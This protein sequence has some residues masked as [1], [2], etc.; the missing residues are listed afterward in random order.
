MKKVIAIVALLMIVAQAC[1][2]IDVYERTVSFPDHTWRSADS[3]SFS[4]EIA[5]SINPYQAFFVLRHSDAYH[6]KNIWVDI[7]VKDP[8]STYTV[9]REFALANGQQWLGTGMDDMYDHRIAFSK[10]PHTLKKGKYS[11]IV[12]QIMREDP[13]QNVWAAGIRMEKVK[14]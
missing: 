2:T 7:Q 9:T 11:F 1:N 8:D 3:L 4:F 13:L 14:Q 12:R 10:V 6:Y 5:D